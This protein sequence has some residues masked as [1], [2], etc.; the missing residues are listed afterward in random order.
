MVPSSSS[1]KPIITPF[2][3]FN[4]SHRDTW[5]TSGAS[6]GGGGPARRMSATWSTRAGEPSRRWNV[7]TVSGSPR[8]RPTWVRMARTFSSGSSAFFT[9]NGSMDGAM[10]RT[11][12]SSQPG[13]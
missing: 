9:E 13:T 7:G 2:M 11:G 1:A 12:R 10:I 3:S 8:M 6:G 5:M 4:R